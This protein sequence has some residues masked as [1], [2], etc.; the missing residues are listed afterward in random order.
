[1]EDQDVHNYES[2]DAEGQIR[3]LHLEPGAFAEPLVGNLLVRKLGDDEENPPAYSCVS[4]AWGPQKNFTSFTCDG[5]SLRI[6]LVVD[7]ML[8]HLRTPKK[9]RYLWIDA[10][11]C[12]CMLL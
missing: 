1:M 2:I 12:R 11:M 5:K 3:V 8:R 9:A 6:T 4:Y 7:E 10:S